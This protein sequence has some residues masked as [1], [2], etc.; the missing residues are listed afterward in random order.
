MFNLNFPSEKCNSI[1]RVMAIVAVLVE[2]GT[3]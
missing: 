2:L 3:V 1:G